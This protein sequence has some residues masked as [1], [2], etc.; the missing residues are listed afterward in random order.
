MKATV[1]QIEDGYAVILLDDGTII[2][3]KTKDRNLMIGKVLDMKEVNKQRKS[4]FGIALAITA[5]F[6]VLLGSG[7]YAYFTPS[8][9][10]SLDVNPGIV[11]EVNMFERVIKVEAVNED[12]EEV[13]QDLNLNNQNV[14]DA[15]FAAV[16]RVQEMGYLDQENGNNIMIATAARNQ[17]DAQKLTERLQNVVKLQVEAKGINAEV[18]AQGIGYE[19]VEA[20]KAIEGMTPGKYNMIV[21][22]LGIAPEE[23]ANYVDVPVKELMEDYRGGSGNE[24]KQDDQNNSQDPQ[25]NGQNDQDNS[26]QPEDK[27]NQPESD[28]GSGADQSQNG[29]STGGKQ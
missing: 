22:L 10:V 11:M 8:Y 2:K 6:V 24:G 27:G 12:A 4:R 29:G 9:Y 20:A 25:D 5:M 26:N 3:T 1:L 23:A 15:M 14:E 16:E 13:L 28:Q 21:N 17:G 18:M 7:A 19:M